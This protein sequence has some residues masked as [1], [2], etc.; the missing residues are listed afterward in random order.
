MAIGPII[1][2]MIVL[3]LTAFFVYLL[4]NY[5]SAKAYELVQGSMLGGLLS[6]LSEFFKK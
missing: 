2:L 3:I 5:S 4:T 6:D 1:I